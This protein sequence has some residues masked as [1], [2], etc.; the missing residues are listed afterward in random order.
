MHALGAD[1]RIDRTRQLVALLE[2]LAL[3]GAPTGPAPADG[4][5]IGAKAERRTWPIRTGRTVVADPRRQLASRKVSHSTSTSVQTQTR[6]GRGADP[7]ACGRDR[8]GGRAG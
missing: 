8:R 4:F 7:V 5:Q 1:G 3:E 6:V 2:T